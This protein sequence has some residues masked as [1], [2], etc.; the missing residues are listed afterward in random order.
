V[1]VPGRRLLV[2]NYTGTEQE[3]DLTEPANCKGFG[4]IRHFRRA[5]SSG[6]PAN[7]LPIDPACTALGLPTPDLVR[8]QVFQNAVC[9]WRCWYCFVPFSLLSAN[10]RHSAWQSAA[11][12][13]DLYLAEPSPPPILDLTGGQPDLVPEWVFWMMQELRDR[14]LD[15]KVYLWSDDN[16]SNDFFWRFLSEDAREFIATYSM[17]GR[18]CCFKG[19]N[20]ESFVFNTCAAPEHF[21][22][23]FAL[24]KKLLDLG[25][26]LYGYVT[27]TT[28]TATRIAAD[29]ARFVDSL[30]DIDPMLPL[31]VVPLEIKVFTPVV[32]R[33]TDEANVSMENQQV[34][35][36]HWQKELEV[37]FSSEARLRPITAVPLKSSRKQHHARGSVSG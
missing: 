13:V 15:Q 19:F 12:L 23:Q 10:P 22:R 30:Q 14:G 6:W 27:L 18:V 33:L 36:E 17:Y 32:R 1:D 11:E 34:A 21:A 31:R 3:P 9:N 28:P 25:I 16:L 7:P 29:M 35:V 5:T 37:R 2:T 8:S 4:R 24:M 20:E 26:D